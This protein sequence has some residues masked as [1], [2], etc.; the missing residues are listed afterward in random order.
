MGGVAQRAI[1]GHGR[2]L[3]EEGPALVGVARE[4]GLVHSGLDQQRCAGRS[5][6]RVAIAA[7]H[8][9][10]AH[11]ERRGLPEVCALCLV[12][13]EADLRLAALAQHWVAFH[14]QLM[15]IGAGHAATIVRAGV[16]ARPRAILV[17]LQAG[18][19]P[20][21]GRQERV[22]LQAVDRRLLVLGLGVA[23]ARTVASLALQAAGTERRMGITPLC[24]PSLEDPSHLE[25]CRIRLF[26]VA[27]EAG[28]GALFAVLT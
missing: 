16:P 20:L 7:S 26:V 21:F 2:V 9:P 19:V 3:P 10:E 12:A 5:V 23:V 25:G 4:A 18:L 8:A 22:R 27:S 6:G 15:A 11:R 14:M 17:A 28:I 24:M 1:L 13:T